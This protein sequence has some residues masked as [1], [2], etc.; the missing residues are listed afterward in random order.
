MTVVKSPTDKKFDLNKLRYAIP[1]SSN[2]FGYVLG[3]ML[4]FSFAIMGITGVILGLFYN[5]NPDH[6]N[7][8]VSEITSNGFLNYIRGVHVWTAQIIPVMIFLHI[9]RIVL[10]GSY[11]NNRQFNWFIGIV[12][13][14]I[15]LVLIFTGTILKWDQAAFEALEHMEE[16]SSTFGIFG[17][18]LTSEF[19]VN[20]PLLSRVFLLHVS[21]LPL[22]LLV[23]IVLHIIVIKLSGISALPE[24]ENT[25]KEESSLTFLDHV[26]AIAIYS[27]IFFIIVS[28]LALIF[29]QQINPAPIVGVEVTRPIWI[30]LPWYPIENF[31]GVFAVL[32]FPAIITFLLFIIPLIDREE[33]RNPRKG[34]QRIAVGIVL[35]IPFMIL[36]LNI[37]SAI[38]EPAEH[39]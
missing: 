4:L 16:I 35:F 36:I 7:A 20:T 9:L 25:W 17:A 32:V 29:P 19:A 23:F 15:T 18:F 6:A 5:S 33:N 12:L 27:A 14:L 24:E 37:I 39:L 34:R 30:F 8:S 31:V 2:S 22:I 28:L 10:T 3:S 13:F 1:N 26:K 11:K 38:M 21:I